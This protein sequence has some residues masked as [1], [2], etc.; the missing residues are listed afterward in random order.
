MKESQL[1]KLAIATSLVGI[2]LLIII[3]EKA[4]I[5]SSSIASITGNAVGSGVKAKGVI[6]SVKDMAGI[7]VL[8]LKDDTGTIK[9]VIFKED[10]LSLS[11]GDI[12]E[13]EGIV[14]DY[15]GELEIEAEQVKIF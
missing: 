1:V 5:S 6:V 12:I 15:N 3:S 8:S 4:D 11:K 9:V 14:K 2:F 10:E 7:S 13:V